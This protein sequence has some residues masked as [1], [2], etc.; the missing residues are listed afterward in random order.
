MAFMPL[1]GH[2]QE[3]PKVKITTNMG[4]I[5]VELYPDKAPKTWPTSFNM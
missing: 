1:L 4:E 2:A 5:M 3:S